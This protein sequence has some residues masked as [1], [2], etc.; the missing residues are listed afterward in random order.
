MKKIYFVAS[1]FLFVMLSGC[2]HY[3]YTE[4]QLEMFDTVKE[5]QIISTPLYREIKDKIKTVAII[6]PDFCQQQSAFSANIQQVN[7][8]RSNCGVALGVIEKDLI[9]QGFNV[10]SWEMFESI[11]KGS[12]FFKAGKELDIDV[13]FSINSLENITADS[14]NINLERKYYKS[15]RYGNKGELWNLQESHKEKVRKILRGYEG[16]IPKSSMGAA[17]DVAAIDVKTGKSIWYYQASFYNV[18]KEERKLTAAIR[19]KKN[20]WTIFQINGNP[21]KNIVKGNIDENRSYDKENKK[22]KLNDRIFLKYLKKGVSA[23]VTSFKKGD[24]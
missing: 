13:I 1:C 17:I 21:V 18:E 8:I 24:N 2:S 12:S 10:I 23:F 16:I 19:G 15:D 22:S 20:I 4:S 6:A 7:F 5:P 14:L 3:L 9:S 11:A